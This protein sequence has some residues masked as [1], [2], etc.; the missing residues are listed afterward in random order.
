M[1][2]IIIIFFVKA[3]VLAEPTNNQFYIQKKWHTY[4]NLI[5][6]YMFEPFGV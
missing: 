6:N 5:G 4:L 3:L 1:F 2:A